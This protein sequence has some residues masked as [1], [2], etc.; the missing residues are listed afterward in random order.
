MRRTSMW[1][2]VKMAACVVAVA[3]AMSGLALA[4]YGRDDDDGYYRQGNSAQAR[5]YGYQQGYN[6]GVSKGQHEGREHDPYDYQTP[7]WRQATRGY[8]RWM[9]EVSWYQRGYQN[10]YSNGFRSGYQSVAGQRG[11]RDGDGDRWSFNGSRGYDPY[12]ASYQNVASQFGFED[13]AAVARADLQNGKAYNSRPRG[14]FDDCDRGYRR[15]YGS[16]D[17]YKA[18]YASAYSNGYESVMRRRY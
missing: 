6:D 9:G 16:K 13:G 2:T 18:E 1:R 12:Q 4:Q 17:Q 3:V 11:D 5:Q 14:R 15:E 10:G 8:Q 7:D